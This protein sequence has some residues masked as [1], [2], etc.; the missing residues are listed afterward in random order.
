M[1]YTVKIKP[2]SDTAKLP[3]FKSEGAAAMDVYAASSHTVPPMKTCVIPCGFALEAPGFIDVQLRP[4]SGLS[5]NGMLVSFGTI[6][7][8]YRGEVGV[9]ITNISNESYDVKAGDRVAQLAMAENMARRVR[10][11]VVEHLT[12]TKRGEGGFGSTGR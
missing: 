1:T 12:E 6:D 5:K 11:S 2:L 4:R 3:S 10:F 9:I 7:P 8:D